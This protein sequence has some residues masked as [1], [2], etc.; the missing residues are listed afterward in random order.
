MPSQKKESKP[1]E[2]KVELPAIGGRRLSPGSG[3][4][5]SWHD[6]NSMITRITTTF[7][8]DWEKFYA[9]NRV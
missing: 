5:T 2:K 3:G 4:K 1:L 7:A 6:F 9:Q 8:F